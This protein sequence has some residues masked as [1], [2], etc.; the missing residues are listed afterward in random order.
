MKLTE[1]CSLTWYLL[2]TL[3]IRATLLSTFSI[4]LVL[5]TL[6]YL[7]HIYIT[8]VQL[9]AHTVEIKKKSV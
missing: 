6:K 9:Y 2:F 8:Q 4:L 7:K 3:I 1:I 5:N